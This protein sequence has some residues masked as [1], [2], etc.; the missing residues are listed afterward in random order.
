M[1]LGGNA[2][3]YCEVSNT[4]DLK[5][6]IDFAKENNI[7]YKVIGEGSNIIWKDS[8]FNGLVIKNNLKG[9]EVLN[10]TDEHA[11]IKVASGEMLDDF[12]QKM[13][14]KNLSGIE[15]LSLIP[16][17]VGATPVQNVGAYGQEISDTLLEVYAIDS[18]TGNEVVITNK[19]CNFS[20]RS[21][22][23]KTSAKD[24]YVI[25]AISLRLSKTPLD[26]PFY[27]SLQDYLSNNQITDYSPKNI[28]NAVI[29][30]RSSKL[31]DWHK[32]ANS[33]S[34]FSNPIISKEQYSKILEQHP[35]APGW[36]YGSGVK[37]PAA[38]LIEKAGFKDFH[39]KDT[40]IGTWKSQAL[41]LINENATSTESLL[42]I[43]AEI[44]NK[45]KDLFDI[46]LEQEPELLP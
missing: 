8:G 41:V 12:I 16:G 46:T 18:I 37:I 30:I 11:D 32:V 20:Y 7:P 14:D 1:R 25:T 34:F 45:V 27:Q 19:D 44:V 9:F 15:C 22:I 42:K 3:F 36:H 6:A 38:W 21:S 5:K 24:K 39:D 43:K 2:D 26:P 17:T 10:E 28:R 23:F 4:D 29:D 31:P 13:T 33:G 35:N 40:G